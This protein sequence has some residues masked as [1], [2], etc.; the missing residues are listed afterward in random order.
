MSYNARGRHNTSRSRCTFHVLIFDSQNLIIRGRAHRIFCVHLYIYI[1][2]HINALYIYIYI[3]R[4]GHTFPVEPNAHA[5]NATYAGCS[6]IGLYST[7][8]R[9]TL[10]Y[11][12]V[13][14]TI[15]Q[16]PLQCLD[17]AHRDASCCNTVALYCTELAHCY[18]TL[19]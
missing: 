11:N 14:F 3:Y 8:H 2:I 17:M 13:R 5:C 10:A 7:S 19:A 15:A 6:S 18:S 12:R 9:S 16:S 1:Y 4:H